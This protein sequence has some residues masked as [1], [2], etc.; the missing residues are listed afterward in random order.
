MSAPDE[1]RYKAEEVAE[2]V[3]IMDESHYK[4]NI[5]IK[6]PKDPDLIE[7]DTIYEVYGTPQAV[8]SALIC[9]YCSIAESE[10]H[11]PLKD[12]IES[13]TEHLTKYYNTPTIN[14]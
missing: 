9:S 11:I 8:M 1:N 2:D 6:I 14:T 10:L 5:N 4:A 12:L 3:N 13:T 7:S